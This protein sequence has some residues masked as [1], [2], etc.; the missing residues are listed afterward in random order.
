MCIL[1]CY[2]V[3]FLSLPQLFFCL[4]FSSGEMAKCTFSTLEIFLIFL[5]VMM[6]GITVALLSLLFIT[7]GTTENHT[8][9][10]HGFSCMLFPACRKFLHFGGHQGKKQCLLIMLVTGQFNVY[11][12]SLGRL[13]NLYLSCPLCIDS[14]FYQVD[15]WPK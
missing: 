12:S 6:T 8:G 13:S 1:I 9:K 2:S 7:S 5:F 10:Y 3:F 4:C 11:L 15:L 14:S